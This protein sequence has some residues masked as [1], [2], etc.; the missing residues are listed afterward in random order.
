[1]NNE[2]NYSNNYSNNYLANNIN[3]NY[4]I[5]ELFDDDE[6]IQEESS[7]DELEIKLCKRQSNNL[8]DEKNKKNGVFKRNYE[9]DDDDEN[10]NENEN[11][12]EDE[13]TDRDYYNGNK[14]ILEE[15]S[16]N[17][18]E[19]KLCDRNSNHLENDRNDFDIKKYMEPTIIENICL[20]KYFSLYDIEKAEKNKKQLKITD[21]G[22]YSISKYQDAQWISHEIIR[23]LNSQNINACEETIIDST[24]CVGG[25]TINFTRYFKFVE[26]IEINPTHYKVLKNNIEA[27]SIQNARIHL[28]SFLNIYQ[29]FSNKI[30]Y[31]DPPWGRSLYKKFKYFNL[32]IGKYPISTIINMLYDAHF[33]YFILKAPCNLNLS[34]LYGYVNYQNLNIIRNLK[35]NMILCI[36]Y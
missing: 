31:M 17:E 11:E 5:K 33:E 24:A 25:N 8:E 34:S 36:F 14:K 2:I 12:N 23:F 28:D 3:I 26:A 18:F 6:E 4:S 21:K 7:E 1:M 13:S 32:K 30:F 20:E 22:L 19:V 35:K 15:W 16:E 9:D 29:N 27:L 10:E